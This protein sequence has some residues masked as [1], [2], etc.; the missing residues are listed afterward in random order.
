MNLPTGTVTYLFT[1]IEGSTRLWENFPE[2]MAAEL[3]VH[4]A[5]MKSE[6]E[7]HGGYVF[8]TI[9]DAFCAAFPTALQAAQATVAAQARLQSRANTD[10]SKVAIRVRMAVHTGTAELRDN[11]YFGQPL[12]RTARLLS[13][14]HGG[15]V[16]LSQSTFELIRDAMPLGAGVL[17]LGQHRLKDLHRP[18]QINQLTHEQ[19]SLSF[20]P[21]RT[22]D[23]PS[24]PNNLPN[25]LSSFVGRVNEIAQIKMRLTTGRLVTLTGSGGCG[26]TRLCCQIAAE[27]LEDY[28]DGVWLVELASLT[29]RGHVSK[30][31]AESVGIREVPGEQMTTTLVGYLGVR[32]SMIILDNCEH[33]LEEV[34]SLVDAILRRCSN[35][36]VLASSRE[37]LGLLGEQAFR[38]P[39]LSIPDLTDRHTPES[40]TQYEAVRL[41]VERAAGVKADFAVTNQNA[42]SVASIC[43]QLDGIPFAIELAA[44][45]VRSLTVEQISGH[46]DNRFGLLTGGSRMALPRQQTLRTMIDWSYDLLAE[47]QKTFLKRLSV[48]AGGWRMEAAEAVRCNGDV[49]PWMA[50]DLT[51]S[52]VDKSLVVAG[53][54]GSAVRYRL[55]ETVRQ[56]SHDRLVESGER[57]RTRELHSDWYLSLAAAAASQLTGRDQ[58]SWA[59]R[60]EEEIDNLRAGFDY[61]LQRSAATSALQYCRSLQHFWRM[62]GHYAEGRSACERALD[63][64]PDTATFEDRA[65]VLTAAGAIALHQADYRS[66]NAYL[67][68]SIKLHSDVAPREGHAAALNLLGWVKVVEGGDLA[69]AHDLHQESLGIRRSSNDAF[70]I[71]WSLESLGFVAWKQGSFELAKEY[72]EESLSLRRSIGDS[73]GTSR[74]LNS[75][76]MV[77]LSQGYLVNAEKYLKEGLQIRREL[78]HRLGIAWSLEGFAQLAARIGRLANAAVYW[79]AA[80]LLREEMGSPLS[81][82]EV[83]IHKAGVES[84]ESVLGMEV[85]HEHYSR[86]RSMPLERVLAQALG[87]LQ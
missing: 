17:D 24:T 76:G 63:Y 41:F 77:A 73:D 52:L 71:A 5:L 20:P 50:L 2:Q 14:G 72:L 43:H 38:V 78:G 39:S 36:T 58:S 25:Q 1:D 51:T 30:A 9:G 12:N 62:K 55:L 31:L 13:A 49:D 11:D 61:C 64:L 34:S 59:N 60:L 37:A 86:G 85:Y 7:S 33:V 10:S 3:A 4:D 45:R 40:L 67:E 69:Q 23:N 54:R 65:G 15:Q 44:A 81:P 28:P 32:K 87:E 74:S 84:I 21:L 70:G 42:P 80:E 47:D 79:G 35:V 68:E 16:L 19:I 46:L 22:L 27:V 56:Y 66:A 53:D 29:E 26:K 75:L 83:D 57:D 6:I 8:K 82:I 18:E 48:F